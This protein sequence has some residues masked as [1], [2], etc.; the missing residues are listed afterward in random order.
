MVDMP[1]NQNQTKSMERSKPNQKL[2]K[3]MAKTWTRIPNAHNTITNTKPG[4]PL[5]ESITEYF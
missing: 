3:P 4:N 1:Q 2:T 5:D